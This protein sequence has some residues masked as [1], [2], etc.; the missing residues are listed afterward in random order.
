MVRGD[1]VSIYLTGKD[2]TLFFDSNSAVSLVA[3]ASGSLEGVIIFQDRAYL[4]VH[5][6]NSSEAVDLHGTI[7]LPGGDLESES[8]SAITPLSSCSVII[9]RTIEFDSNSGVSIDLN[10][11]RCLRSLPKAL[12]GAVVLFE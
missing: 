8:L 10:D 11:S 7:Y 3:P 5:R 4:G 6:W 1:N 9:A 12:R 2:A